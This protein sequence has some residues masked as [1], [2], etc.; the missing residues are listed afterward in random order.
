MIKACQELGAKIEVLEDKLKI[1][2]VSGKLKLPSNVIDAGNSGQVLRFVG[3]IAGLIDGYTVLTGDKSVRF[4]RP[5]KPLTDGLQNLGATCISTKGD[6]YAPI[7][8]KG[9]ITPGI[10]TFDGADSQPVSAILIAAAFLNGMTKIKVNNPGEKPWIGV[11]LAWL[12]KFNIKYTNNNFENY[13][14]FG[15]NAIQ[16]FN[17]EVPGDFSS[18]AFPLVAA[19]VTRSKLTIKNLDM[20]DAQGDK[21]LIQA[22]SKMGAD[23][24][25]QQ[26]SL[27][28]CGKSELNGAEI[29]INNFIDALPI[30]AVLGCYAKGTTKLINAGIARC[31]ESDRLAAITTELR[32]MGA[33]IEEDAT[34]LTI[35]NSKLIAADLDSHSDHRIAMALAVASLGVEDFSKINNINCISKSYPSFLNDM[36]NIGAAIEVLE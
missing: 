22:L 36:Q 2:G 7:I 13:T 25:I 21:I 5:L 24:K 17:Y 18:I 28:V 26:N 11:T 35:K 34:S 9:P 30:L 14:I 16:A 20:Q 19:I 10:T 3:A 27:E 31:K 8:I 32:K 12:D 4:N 6:G 33:I 1:I 15:P 29:D 23:I